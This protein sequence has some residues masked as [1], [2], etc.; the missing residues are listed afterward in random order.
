M[1][2]IK[3]AVQSELNGKV[4]D[5][6]IELVKKDC[7]FSPSTG[8]TVT[9]ELL[10]KDKV[11]VIMGPVSSAV[12]LAMKPVIDKAGTATWIDINAAT[13]HLISQNC[14]P[15]FIRASYSTYTIGHP[16]GKWTYDNLGKTAV[17]AV[18]DYDFGHAAASAFKSAYKDAG[19]KVVKNI[20]TSPSLSDYAPVVRNMANTGADAVFCIYTSTAAANFMKAAQSFGLK[21]KMAITGYSPAEPPVHKALPDATTGV[22]TEESYSIQLDNPTNQRFIKQYKSMYGKNKYPS[23]DDE[24]SYVGFQM[25]EKGVTE[26]K[27]KKPQDVIPELRGATIHAPR[28]DI[29]IDPT[30]QEILSP[31]LVEK[32]TGPKRTD[33]KILE[34]FDPVKSPNYGCDISGTFQ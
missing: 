34:K 32:A 30:T 28:G 17:V 9:R 8:V 27:S 16:M 10:N 18:M 25:L 1:E 7:K 23:T 26:A 13:T 24:F 5:Y 14:S 22:T 31:M 11:D 33:Y 6:E 3:L 29:K 2:G 20:S 4:G 15:Y 21:D 12:G 19:G